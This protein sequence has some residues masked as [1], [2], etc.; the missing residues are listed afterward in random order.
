MAT[1][2]ATLQD[3]TPITINKSGPG[4]LTIKDLV[5]GGYMAVGLGILTALQ[6]LIANGADQIFSP[7]AGKTV[8]LAAVG[9]LVTYLLK[10]L[11]SEQHSVVAEINWPDKI[12]N[13]QTLSELD[14]MQPEVPAEFMPLWTQ[15]YQDI[16]NGHG[17]TT[18]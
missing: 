4:Q 13:A 10:N 9:G 2:S 14:Q 11:F 1:Q 8:G 17:G 16:A 5:K 18:K 7:H 3:G 15:R 12:A 6:Q